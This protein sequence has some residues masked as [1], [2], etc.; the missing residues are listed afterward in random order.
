MTNFVNAGIESKEE[1]V[2]RLVNGE[3]FYLGEYKLFLDCSRP[4]PFRR[5]DCPILADNWDD[6]KK[7]KKE[8]IWYEQPD[9]FPRLCWV[10]DYGGQ[11]KLLEVI[12]K[13]NV[14]LMFIDKDGEGWRYAE[15][16]EKG[17][18]NHLIK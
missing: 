7:W 6:F 11:G 2:K 14:D 16:V 4:S 8:E 13:C 9:A 12:T 10:W 1:A 5:G 18:L 3:V 17:E 15:P